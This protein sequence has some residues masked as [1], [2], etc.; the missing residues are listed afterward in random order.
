M[1]VWRIR[2]LLSSQELIAEGRRMSHCVASYANSCHK[3]ICSI[4]SMEVE[5]D[6]GT[7]PLLT[8]E[9]NH[10]RKEMCQARG[11]ANRLPT[12]KEKDILRRW[13]AKEQL[14]ATTLAR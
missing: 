10:Q 7:E 1:K 6:F 11:K 14:L 8:I 4:W 9:V 2:E 12:D 5:T 13:A 3:G